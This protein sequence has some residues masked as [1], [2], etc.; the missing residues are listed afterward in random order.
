MT[1]YFFITLFALV[2]FFSAIFYL[3]SKRSTKKKFLDSLGLKLFLVK[4]PKVKK[5]GK[6]LK[7]EILV[8]EQFL[9]ALT[10]FKRPFVFEVA[11]PYIGEEIHFYVAVEEKLE[12]ALVRQIESI[13]GD[14][15][16][17][18]VD[19]YNIFN[20]SGA[21]AGVWAR[22]K[23]RFILPI[24][25]YEELNADTFS[26][27]LGG[28][29]KINEFGEGGAIQFVV[30]PAEPSLKK[31]I[32]SALRVLKKG[33]KLKE[34]LE[35][36][37]A[38]SFS[39]VT[40][41]LSPKNKKDQ[42]EKVLDEVAIE[43]L[44]RKLSKPLFGVNVRVIASAP[45]KEQAESILDGII[46]GFS[47]FGAPDRNSFA[48]V[49][50]RNLESLVYRFSFREFDKDQEMIL[51]SEELASL[52][53]F[54]TAFTE[55]PTIKFVKAKE[56]SLPADL[57]KSGN[58]IGESV[59]RGEA[60]PV[61]ISDEDRRRHVYVVGQTGTGK[62]NLLTNMVLNDVKAGKGVG[63]IDPH[64]DLIEN[65]LALIPKKRFED[66]I[67]FDPSDI[68]YPL[69]L[70]M[71]EYDWNHPEE[72]TFIV[73][74]M[75][76]IFNKLF[77]PET[78]G[79]M[80]EQY[81]RNA[82]LLLMEAANPAAVGEP[83][84]LMEVPRVFT[85]PEYRNRKLA[86]IFNPAVTDFWTKEAVKAG[87]EASLSNMTPYI[88]SKFN[89]FTSNDYMRVII[90][91]AKSAFRFRE[92]MDQG[93]ILLISLTKGKI[94]DI[95]ANLLGMILVGKLL[96]AALGRVDVP[97][98]K[99]RDFNLYIDEF[100]NFTTD[101]IATILSE[102]RKYRLNL[103]IAHQFIGQLTE[104]VRDAVFGNVGSVVAFRVGA[105]DSEFLV[106]QFSP[107]FTEEDLVNIDNFNAYVKLLANGETTRP[108]NIRTLK[109]EAGE[110]TLI[111]ELRELSRN[112]Y[113]R[114]RE[115]VEEDIYKRLRE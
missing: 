17:E 42:A 77:P 41:A 61:F 101:S 90:G 45:K 56:S 98:E 95:N 44:Q 6:D 93:K 58:L 105:Q 87:G 23:E 34:V 10:A 29:A 40:E 67:V 74:E 75:Q 109:S 15:Q 22:L 54:P 11:V 112:K 65:I 69:G 4:L 103:T 91:Q 43:A 30:K 49:K 24:R 48:L 50:P 86:R 51:T 81:M 2:L 96:M 68:N 55:I 9:S 80:F 63:I 36:P 110:R 13:W 28:L 64:R 8:S 27:I 60:K 72:K 3:I 83:A 19:D 97:E 1:A 66:V 16:V 20:Y 52:V 5:E 115:E 7:Q 39:D 57:P 111:S 26:P 82:L 88:T 113:G 21:T 62:S 70:N 108:F 85:D 76:S 47:Q 107:V 31:Q 18:K 71:L 12:E 84:T 106:K 53:H 59:Y 78:M 102:A 37:L 73:N 114:K 46:A 94:G 25:T 35:R 104:K 92:C 99:R 32:Q 33:W 38:M 79:P 89:N 14:A 100:Q